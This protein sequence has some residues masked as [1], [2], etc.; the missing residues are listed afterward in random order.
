MTIEPTAKLHPDASQAGQACLDETTAARLLAGE[1]PADEADLAHGHIATCRDCERFVAELARACVESS[2]AAEPEPP[3]AA[4]D[5]ELRRGTTVGRFLVLGRIGAGGMGVVHAAYDPELDRRVALK[6]LRSDGAAQHDDVR[7]RLLREAQAAA[8]LS[9]PNV[10]SVFDIGVFEDRVYLAMEY[11]EGATLAEWLRGD[12]SW[13][14]VIDV[15]LQA[16]RGIAAAHQAGVIHRDFKPDNVLVGRDGRARVVDF[17]LARAA[18]AEPTPH[19]DVTTEVDPDETQ[20]ASG[21]DGI[22]SRLTRTGALL[23]TPRYMA[24]EQ[25]TGGAITPNTDQFGFCVALYHALYHTAPFRGDRVSAIASQVLAGEI[26]APLEHRGPIGIRRAIVRGL[27]TDPARRH[28]SMPA[29]IRELERARSG[30]RRRRHVALAALAT[31]LVVGITLVLA[32]GV[33]DEAAP[34]CLA[35]A[36]KVGAVWNA[37]QKARVHAAFAAPGLPYG[38]RSWRGIEARLDAYTDAWAAMR[39]EAC[40][41]THILHEQSPQLLDLRVGCLDDRLAELTAF[42]GV[43]E[44][45]DAETVR[46][47]I[48]GADRL[49]KLTPCADRSALAAAIRPPD[50]ASASQVAILDDQLARASALHRVGKLQLALAAAERACTHVES[51]A[52]PPVTARCRYAVGTLVNEAAGDPGRAAD[53]LTDAVTQA[54]AGNDHGQ[55]ADAAVAL[56]GVLGEGLDRFDEADRW[57]KLADG[58]GARLADRGELDAR[59][60]GVRGVLASGRGHHTEALAHFEKLLALRERLHVHAG[61]GAGDSGLHAGPGGDLPVANADVA[62]GHALV[63]LGRFADAEP[64]Y[65]R[66]LAVTE[67]VSGAAHPNLLAV[68]DGLG[69]LQW[70][71]GRPADAIPYYERSLAITRAT[72]PPGHP[73]LVTALANLGAAL[74]NT[75]DLERALKTLEEA[76]TSVAS[77]TNR[78]A[79]ALVLTNLVVVYQL[80][81]DHARAFTTAE[82]ALAAERDVKGEAH[83]DT[84]LAHFNVGDTLLSLDRPR[85]AVAALRKALAIWERSLPAHH[86]YLAAGRTAIGD[87]LIRAGDPRAAIPALELAIA[88]HETTHGDATGVARARFLLARASWM[89]SGDRKRAVALAAAAADGL[90]HTGGTNAALLGEIE[91]WIAHP[92]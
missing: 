88:D 32:P 46:R 81:G 83:T 62:V 15:F 73:S 33:L 59:L 4:P 77:G 12:R 18:D 72:V 28:A 52:Y 58:A 6:L 68:L 30:P 19:L 44:A 55:T 90:R 89:T 36:A 41:A 17:G 39:N 86:P 78:R 1:L 21:G 25:F 84:G 27:A 40:A 87:A 16:G 42:I 76:R 57:T 13:Q 38:E 51:L 91:Q 48:D 24:P 71:L 23:G 60:S 92:R 20:P 43:L 64:H 45:A 10:V 29:L 61:P 14:Q 65:R 63:A 35:A 74:M 47:S 37:D 82:Q 31:A 53:L 9:H 2:M 11:V 8:R 70:S 5:G 80:R 49:S 75:G 3:F 34:P 22:G 50:A 67:E 85:D 69:Q 66:A 79:L 7:A 54:I 26:Q 56:A